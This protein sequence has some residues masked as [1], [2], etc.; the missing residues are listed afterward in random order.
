MQREK[1]SKAA[2]TFQK[3]FFYHFPIFFATA[4]LASEKSFTFNKQ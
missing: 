3:E 1:A 4:R 2:S